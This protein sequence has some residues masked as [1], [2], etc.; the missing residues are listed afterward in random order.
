MKPFIPGLIYP[1]V[2]PRVPMLAAAATAYTPKAWHDERGAC[3]EPSNQG[4]SSECVLYSYCGMAEVRNWRV[5]GIKCQLD[6]HPAYLEAKR[7]D[8]MPNTPGT[9]LQAGLEAM[10]AVGYLSQVDAASVR[11]VGTIDELK[12]ALHRYGVVVVSWNATDKFVSPAHDGWIQSGG[13]YIGGHAT[14][15]CYFDEADQLGGERGSIGCQD[16]YGEARGDHGFWRL[17]EPE[18]RRIFA[19]GIVFDFLA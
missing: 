13:Q 16:N 18:A 15:C 6:P 2:M 11:T 4:A 19:G 17:T 10:I 8:G 3:L 5:D 12:R 9:T 1:N 14:L 7:R